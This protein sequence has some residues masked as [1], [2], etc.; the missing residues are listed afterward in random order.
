MVSKNIIQSILVILLII[1]TAFFY[2]KYIHKSNSVNSY[3]KIENEE[4][5]SNE[6]IIVNENKDSSNVIENLRYTSKDLFGNTYII[7]AQSAKVQEGEINQVQL[8]EVMAKI[9]QQNDETIYINS[10]FADYNKLNNNT[11]FKKNVNVK[12]GDQSIDAN[13]INLNFSKN[14]IKIE[15]DVYYKNNNANINAD[16]IEI[17]IESKKLNISM[18]KKHDKVEISAKY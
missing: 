8:F 3:T 15:E 14:L 17:D 4:K 11:I 13:T 10:D 2:Q 16:K 1:L 12:Y 5:I 6:E 9:I 7:N 18:N